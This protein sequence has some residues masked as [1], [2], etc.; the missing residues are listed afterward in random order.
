ML[1]MRSPDLKAE[2]VIM[3]CLLRAVA[4]FTGIDRSVSNNGGSI[5]EKI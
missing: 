3:C 4:H 2:D 1:E 5:L